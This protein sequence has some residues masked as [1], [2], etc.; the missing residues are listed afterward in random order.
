M[1]LVRAIV[2]SAFAVCA[3]DRMRHVPGH[4]EERK[5]GILLLLQMEDSRR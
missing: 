1:G 4:R 2:K 5:G 3:D